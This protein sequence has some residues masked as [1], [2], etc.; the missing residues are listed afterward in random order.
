MKRTLQLLLVAAAMAP[1]GALSAQVGGPEIAFDAVDPL[2]FP[3]DIH[4]GEAAGVALSWAAEREPG[5]INAPAPVMSKARVSAKVRIMVVGTFG[6]RAVT[7][8]GVVV[9][10]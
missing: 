7:L 9:T 5:A 1:G 3:D 2:R 8:C 10:W 6:V 4:L